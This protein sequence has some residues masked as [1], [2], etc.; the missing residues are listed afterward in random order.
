MTKM[1]LRFVLLFEKCL[2]SIEL[3]F[4]NDK[5]MQCMQV[6][7]VQAAQ[8]FARDQMEHFKIGFKQPPQT[9]AGK[10]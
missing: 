8:A 3:Q 5:C 9:E 4:M 7:L 10:V 1:T 2:K 6:L